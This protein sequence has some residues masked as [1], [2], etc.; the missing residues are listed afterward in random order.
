MNAY[1]ASTI[2]AEKLGAEVLFRVPRPA[3]ARLA[4]TVEFL[5]VASRRLALVV[6]PPHAKYAIDNGEGLK[7][8]AGRGT[9]IFSASPVFLLY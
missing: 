8:I 9:V 7:V 2:T 4:D 5:D 3:D 1:V 6:V